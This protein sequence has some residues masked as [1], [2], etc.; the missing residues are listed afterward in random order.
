MTY[1]ILTPEGYPLSSGSNF[2]FEMRENSAGLVDR[3]VTFIGRGANAALPE[4]KV[5]IRCEV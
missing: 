3:I 1:Q 2:K 4:E 5:I